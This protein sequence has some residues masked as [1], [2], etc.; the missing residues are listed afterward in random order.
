MGET[1]SDSLLKTAF[2]FAE[3]ALA[4]GRVIMDVRREGF[5]TCWKADASPVTKADQAAEA[6]VVERLEEACPGIPV[7]AEELVA[8]GRVPQTGRRFILV[9]PL[10]GTREF[11]AGRDEFTVN[12]ALIEDETPVCGAVYAPALGRLWFAGREAFALNA[13][14]DARIDLAAA[15]RI[16]VRAMPDTGPEALVSLSHLDAGTEAY[17]DRLHVAGR[18]QLGSSLKFCL[19]AEGEAD[20]YPRCGPTSEWDI[21]AGHAILAA[22]GGAVVLP[23]GRPLRYGNRAGG[24]RLSGFVACGGIR[25]EGDTFHPITLKA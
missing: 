17:L 12:V 16:R 2:R 1:R 6:L 15:R 3:I 5:A 10:D 23:D 18:R 20:L 13:G 14:P 19:I 11:I 4:A 24:F 25:I 7:V 8:S 22:A 9:D 21:A